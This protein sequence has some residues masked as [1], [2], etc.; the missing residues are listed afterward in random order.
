[1]LDLDPD[2]DLRLFV[3]GQPLT[4]LLGRAIIGLGRLIRELAPAL[5]IVQGDTTTAL[6]GAL[7]AFQEE[8]PVGHVEAG[9][10]TEDLLRPFP[11]EANRRLITRISTLHFAPTEL[12]RERLEGEGVSP[13]SISVPGNTVLDTLRVVGT[14]AIPRPVGG[15]RLALVTVHRRE[16][17]GA[18]LRR[19][20]RA[21][22]ELARLEPDLDVC[23][24][25]HPNPRVRMPFAQIPGI[26]VVDP[27]PYD[28]F[29]GLLATADVVL[30]DS[31]GIQE[32]A[33]SLGTPVVLLRELTERPEAVETGFVKLAGSDP[34]RIVA[35]A[36]AFLAAG[37]PAPADPNP[38]GD[39]HAA[40]R[41]VGVCE[42]HLGRL[43]TVAS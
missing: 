38:F 40:D 21:V 18:P 30:T 10:R 4:D 29:V 23:V 35:H 9:L 19:I 3:P 8:V 32:E 31:G 24:P 12:A 6:A 36:R 42:R 11:E 1:M 5:M 28:R 34:G 22:G 33:P 43:E 7:A 41:I 2:H 37:R 27:L 26:Q 39:G 13:L 17:W 25:A 16:T 15:R 20:A 14:R